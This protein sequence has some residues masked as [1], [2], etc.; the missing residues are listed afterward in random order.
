[1]PRIDSVDCGAGEWPIRVEDPDNDVGLLV[2]NDE[3]KVIRASP[4]DKKLAS[5]DAGPSALGPRSWRTKTDAA[6]H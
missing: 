4:A 5:K 1:V 6:E 2:L 3:F